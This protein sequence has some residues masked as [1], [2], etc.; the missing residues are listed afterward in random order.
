M[1]SWVMAGMGVCML[2]LAG[3]ALARGR[4]AGAAALVVVLIC[5]G[6]AYDNFAIAAGRPL[7]FGGTLEAVSAP[8]FWIHALLTP[9]LIVAGGLMAARLGVRWAASRPV[10]IAG[11]V[12]VVVLIAI[13]VFEDVLELELAPETHEDLLRYTNE[14]TAGPPI[15]AIV[16]ILVLLALGV[17]I[18]RT[19]GSPWLCLG[20]IAMFAAAA[21]GG[22]RPW[23]GNLG[24]L[25]LQVS[26]VATLVAARTEVSPPRVR[27]SGGRT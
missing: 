26:V 1:F 2:A 14:G 20:S 11:G 6:L 15:P 13:G 12:L 21:L 24:E 19:A 16:T 10:A 9:L 18:W 27:E 8:R 5:L 17:A 3:V 22:S 7:G 23:L 4:A 25:A